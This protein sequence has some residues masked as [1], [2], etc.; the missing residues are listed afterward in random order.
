MVYGVTWGH[1]GSY[2]RE[3]QLRLYKST[4]FNET[5]YSKILHFRLAQFDL[6]PN[7][8]NTNVATVRIFKVAPIANVLRVWT[9]LVR[10]HTAKGFG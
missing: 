7:I 2:P 6:L 3:L 9:A 5:L 1:M 4:E 10:H 8:N